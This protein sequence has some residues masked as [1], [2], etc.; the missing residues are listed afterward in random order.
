MKCEFYG[1]TLG[2]KAAAAV[3][4]L[5]LFGF[6]FIHML[7]NLKA[8]AG[9]DE[10]SGAYKLDIYA[11][12]LR[13][14]GEHFVGRETVLWGTRFVLLAAVL[15]H[16]ISVAKLRAIA[17]KARPEGY[18]A[19]RYSSATL[20]ARMM[21]F[22]G[23]ILLA[24]IIFH[25]LHFTTGQVHFYGFVEGRVYSNVYRAFEHGYLVAIYGIAMA[26]L[27]LHLYHGGW[28][29]FQTLGLD[30]PDRNPKIRLL[31]KAA[32]VIICIGFFSVPFA[33]YSGVLPPPAKAVNPVEE[34]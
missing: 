30:N 2:K 9:F 7:G 3:S 20:S 10:G 21:W 14:I 4:G 8:F 11:K 19:Q 33:V 34:Y 28:S 27:G 29:L 31:A 15:V 1:S 23:L 24:F 26:A 22:G 12:T 13:E 25:I 17:A 32:A 5:I 6:V 18:R 16:F